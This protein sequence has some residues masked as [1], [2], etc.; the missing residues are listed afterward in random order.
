MRG[1]HF[2][3]LL[4]AVLLSPIQDSLATS[5]FRCVDANGHVTFTRHGCKSDQEQ[6]LQDARNHTPSSGKA[7]PLANTPKR[8]KPATSQ[9]DLVIVGQHDDGC[10]NLISSSERRQAI[11]R[12]EIRSGMSRADV[13]SSLG[14]PDR[15]TRQNGRQRYYYDDKRGKRQQI[16]FD[17]AGCVKK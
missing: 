16:N 3:A 2:A 17:E 10:G 4:T 7:I 11:I 9:E 1:S 13:E 6:H 12:Q 8:P 15:I 5:V 14:K